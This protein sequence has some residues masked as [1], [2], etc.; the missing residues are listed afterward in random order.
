MIVL[1]IKNNDLSPVRSLIV[2]SS[3]RLL[4]REISAEKV[5]LLLEKGDFRGFS[6]DDVVDT[7]NYSNVVSFIEG[8]KVQRFRQMTS[9]LAIS[10]CNFVLRKISVQESFLRKDMSVEK[11]QNELDKIFTKAQ[12]APSAHEAIKIVTT[13]LPQTKFIVSDL[14][15]VVYNLI[16]FYLFTFKNKICVF[17]DSIEYHSGDLSVLYWEELVEWAACLK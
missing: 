17:D 5:T 9:A 7:V 14:E 15:A 12:G 6:L 3:L 1:D 2:S 13:L 4:G 10:L 8:C 16:N 11:L